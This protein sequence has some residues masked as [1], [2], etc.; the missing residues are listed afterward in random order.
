MM[1]LPPKNGNKKEITCKKMKFKKKK[2]SI[3]QMVA[4][5]GLRKE[6]EKKKI[7]KT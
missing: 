7:E 4:N 5:A 3:C 1:T 6:K 2:K